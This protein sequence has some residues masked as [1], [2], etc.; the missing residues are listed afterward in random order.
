[1]SSD[2]KLPEPLRDA[3][4][5][6]VAEADVGR[7]FRGVERRRARMRATRGLFRT[8]ALAVA[9][10]VLVVGASSAWVLREP[11]P[12]PLRTAI[13]EPIER[14]L[15]SDGRFHFEDGS[16]LRTGN[17]TRVRVLESSGQ[18]FVLH[19]VE[20]EILV[21]VRPGGPRR[22][23]VEASRASIEVVGTR[24]FV[25]RRGPRVHVRVERGAVLVRHE[26]LT[27]GLRRL[28]AS[29]ALTLGGPPRP[30]AQRVPAERPVELVEE[31]RVEVARVSRVAPPR[32]ERWRTYAAQQDYERAY[33]ALGPRGTQ[34]Q[35]RTATPEELM[36]LADVALLSGH[37]AD[38]VMP[39]ERLLSHYED[40]AAAPLAAFTLGRIELD[41]IGR[42]GAAA[43]HFELA[44]RSG[45]ARTLVDDARA[46]LAL[47]RSRAGDAEGA[48]NAACEYL[49][50]V[51]NGP[52]AGSMRSLCEGE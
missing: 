49:T 43:Q 23:R 44:L 51:P 12:G 22:W 47:A 42:P 24:F 4:S 2:S 10:L 7:L 19:L 15:V 38:A 11:K 14:S 39:L 1:M 32:E 6:E 50:R 45:L 36:Q 8:P 28:D 40:H 52:R 41:H 5:A 37:A 21:D 30:V 20:G 25:R 3:L 33:V 26:D 17:D 48:R 9:A 16:W 35:A 31:P 34:E 27:D 29:D 18:A 13:G 46:R